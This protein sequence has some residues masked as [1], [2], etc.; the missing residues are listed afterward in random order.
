MK[1]DEMFATVCFIALMS[2]GD[3]GLLGQAPEYIEEKKHIMTRG[4]D[5]F[6]DLDDLRQMK[7]LLWCDQWAFPIPA[8]L[9]T[10]IVENFRTMPGIA[11]PARYD[12]YNGTPG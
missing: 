10:Y 2:G 4:A 7:V 5:A 8:R 6:A 3:Q 9:R 1:P 11:N 12:D